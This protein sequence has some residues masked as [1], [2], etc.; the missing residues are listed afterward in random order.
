[1]FQEMRAKISNAYSILRLSAVAADA[2]GN[3]ADEDADETFDTVE[4]RHRMLHHVADTRHRTVCSV[5]SCL[6][7]SLYF[8][9]IVF[10]KIAYM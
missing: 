5:P 7:F 4:H 1:M 10:K 2:A 9:Q 6:C 3:D 8:V